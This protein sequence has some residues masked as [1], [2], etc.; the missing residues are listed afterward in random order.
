VLGD[1]LQGIFEFGGGVVDWDSDVFPVFDRLDDLEVPWRWR[2]SNP[3]L[4]EWLLELR[5]NLLAGSNTDISSGPLN[6]LIPRTQHGSW[7]SARSSPM[8][9]GPWSR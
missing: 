2:E 3:E 1:P 9:V 4:G 6:G 8:L 5:S 7:R